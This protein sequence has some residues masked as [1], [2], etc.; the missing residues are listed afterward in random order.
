MTLSPPKVSQLLHINQGTRY[1]GQGPQV[2]S[3][4]MTWIWQSPLW[5]GEE[6]GIE[7]M[8]NHNWSLLETDTQEIGQDGRAEGP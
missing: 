6:K 4:A 3:P 2:Q 7:K 5:T 1:L 8:D